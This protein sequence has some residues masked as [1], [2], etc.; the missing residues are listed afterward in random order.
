VVTPLAAIAALVAALLGGGG[1]GALLGSRSKN[2]ALDTDTLIK[3]YEAAQNISE[4]ITDELRDE[5]TRV[6]ERERDCRTELRTLQQEVALLHHQQRTTHL[7][8]ID[9]EEKLDQEGS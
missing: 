1:I 4:K 9:L 3:V 8:V 6:V 7:Q 5:I 2:R